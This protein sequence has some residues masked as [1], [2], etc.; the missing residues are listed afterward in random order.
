MLP[1]CLQLS[2]VEGVRLCDGPVQ[3][4]GGP[5]TDQ[6]EQKHHA[7]TRVLGHRQVHALP[8]LGGNLDDWI[9]YSAMRKTQKKPLNVECSRIRTENPASSIATAT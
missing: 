9:A 3:P 5:V 7:V 1:E 2:P 4:A 8:R 6:L